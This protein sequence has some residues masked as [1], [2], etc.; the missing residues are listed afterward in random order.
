MKFGEKLALL[1][2]LKALSVRDVG[3][4]VG[5]SGNTVSNY[6]RNITTPRSK[7]IINALAQLFELTPEELTDDSVDIF[8]EDPKD[9]T[10]KKVKNTVSKASDGQSV[11]AKGRKAPAE[12]RKA[13]TKDSNTS[14]NDGEA[15]TDSSKAS[16]ATRTF[17]ESLSELRVDK[18]LRQKDMADRLGITLNAYRAMEKKDVRPETAEEYERLAE[19]LGCEVDYL[20]AGAEIT[21][22]TE[23]KKTEPV[24][25]VSH[26]TEPDKPE[27]A[28]DE[29]KKAQSVLTEPEKSGSEKTKPTPAKHKIK[30][31]A[32]IDPDKERSPKAEEPVTAALSG[33]G[34]T[35]VIKAG[36]KAKL[37]VGKKAAEVI[38]SNSSIA[39]A[40]TK[41]KKI[42]VKGKNVGI[43]TITAYGKKGT[44][45]GSWIIQVK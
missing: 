9:K 20:T 26:K 23:P 28:P 5:V 1:R 6:E 33:S 25:T 40:K 39:K 34:H 10:G 36:K 18:G 22:R 16:V 21:V 29:S 42:I 8:P 17:G 15:S 19:I 14:T 43:T 35:E 31:P 41:G 2:K 30:E 3:A 13:S 12:N 32:R 45:L 11:P 24:P 7:D 37:R 44:V 38:F 4:R 27:S